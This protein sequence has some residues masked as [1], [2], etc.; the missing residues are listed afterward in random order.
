METTEIEDRVE[1]VADLENLSVLGKDKVGLAMQLLQTDD[2]NAP[3]PENIRASTNKGETVYNTD[4]GHSG[5]L[6]RRLMGARNHNMCVQ[7]APDIK[8]TDLQLFQMFSFRSFIE[9]VLVHNTNGR[10]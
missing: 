7:F 8:P 9:G 6:H 5:I 10:I 4:W 3:D 2:D 1:E